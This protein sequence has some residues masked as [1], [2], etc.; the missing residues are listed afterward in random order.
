MANLTPLVTAE[1]G[2]DLTTLGTAEAGG[3]AFANDGATLLLVT[4]GGTA[5]T[6]TI[7]A[8]V[9]AA[10]VAGMGRLTKA[11]AGGTVATNSRRIFGP[12]PPAAFN[13]GQ[14]RAVVSYSQVAGVGVAALRVPRGL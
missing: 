8:Q 4:T 12:F 1:A 5:C 13:D 14:G 7:P 9:T 11:N 6:V 3:D 10:E 2:I